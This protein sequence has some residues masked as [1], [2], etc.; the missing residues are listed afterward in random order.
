MHIDRRQL[1]LQ[2]LAIGLVA[3]VPAVAGSPDEDAVAKKVEAFR[4]AQAAAERRS[5]HASPT[6]EL[7]GTW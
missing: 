6:R 1:A 4:A 5:C 2:A 3:A 7:A